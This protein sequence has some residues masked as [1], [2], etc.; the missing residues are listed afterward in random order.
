MARAERARSIANAASSPSWP[1]SNAA[2]AAER[3]D[4]SPFAS[5]VGNRRG[6]ATPQKC[7]SRVHCGR[8]LLLTLSSKVT[9]QRTGARRAYACEF[10]DRLSWSSLGCNQVVCGIIQ[11]MEN[12]VDALVL[13]LLEWVASRERTYREVLEAWELLAPGCRCGR[14]RR[15]AGSSGENVQTAARSSRSHRRAWRCL[16]QSGRQSVGGT[17]E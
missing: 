6:A 15:I 13:D 11:F 17:R 14:M 5:A 8:L 2:A 7:P 3:H 4:Q 9:G 16:E 1:T 12:A 10:C